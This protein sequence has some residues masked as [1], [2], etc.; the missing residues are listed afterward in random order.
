MTLLKVFEPLIVVLS[1]F[2]HYEMW[3]REI[4]DFSFEFECG[5]KDFSFQNV[6]FCHSAKLTY[7]V[8]KSRI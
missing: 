1:D 6:G 8:D 2:D 4:C 7:C 3:T 5:L